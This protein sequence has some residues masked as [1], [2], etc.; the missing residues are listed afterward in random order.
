MS[1]SSRFRSTLVTSLIVLAMLVAAAASAQYSNP[2]RA[3][4]GWAKLPEGRTLG[5]V[6]G[7]YQDPDGQH[8]WLAL[9]G[10]DREPRLRRHA[11][12]QENR[13]EKRVSRSA[14]GT[15]SSS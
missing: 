7:I 9:P 2:Y 10:A 1:D 15:R 6:A 14:G 3:Y 8:M 5:V 13:E 4:Y 12:R 11:R